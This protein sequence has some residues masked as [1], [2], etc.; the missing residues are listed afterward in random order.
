M[1]LSKI[2]IRSSQSNRNEMLRVVSSFLEPSRYAYGCEGFWLYEEPFNESSLVLLSHWQSQ[3][4]LDRYIRS[5]HFSQ[6]LNLL[7]LSDE[8]PEMQ[9]CEVSNIKGI[10][11]IES[12]RLQR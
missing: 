10:E 3:E 1:I 11:V 6:L 5:D 12:A 7:E 4:S 8:S 2:Q 9:F